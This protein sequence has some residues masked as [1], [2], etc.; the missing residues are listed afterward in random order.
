MAASDKI[1]GLFD[2]IKFEN[3][4]KVPTL[5]KEF[6]E[7]KKSFDD[8]PKDVLVQL[9]QCAIDKIDEH[10]NRENGEDMRDFKDVWYDKECVVDDLFA[11]L[12]EEIGFGIYE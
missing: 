8:M 6:S 4:D 10:E 2:K 12:E 11:K 9:L 1:L 3:K 7:K 5:R